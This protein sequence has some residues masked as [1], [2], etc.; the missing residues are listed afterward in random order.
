MNKIHVAII[1]DGNGRWANSRGLPRSSGHFVG[2]RKIVHI[3]NS[4]LEFEIQYL[5]LFAFSTE[6]WGRPR[7]E[8]NSLMNLM[9]FFL[10][11]ETEN[12]RKKGVQIRVI[13]D[14]ENLPIHVK[15]RIFKSQ[16]L[17][18]NNRK[19][20]LNIAFN[21]SGRQDIIYAI[22]CLISRKVDPKAV[23]EQLIS[24]A[25]YTTGLPDVDIVIRTGGE[26]RISNFLLWQTAY[27]YIFFSDILWPD[28]KKEHLGQILKSYELITTKT[29][30][31]NN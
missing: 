7:A 8:V 19:L 2:I 16:E 21:Y 12:F 27:S 20:I 5:T 28:F 11:R 18:S 31:I 4:S 23:N 29:N 30:E 1:M 13:G 9:F 26:K 25:V 3:I 24:E 22:R 6:N 10:D 17:T 15:N 14:I